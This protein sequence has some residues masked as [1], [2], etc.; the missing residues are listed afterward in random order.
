MVPVHWSLVGA[1]V[2]IKLKAVIPTFPESITE[3]SFNKKIVK[4]TY[5]RP[6][7]ELLHIK[8]GHQ[9]KNITGKT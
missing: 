6:H 5:I 7:L 9:M 4:L 2:G 3:Q 8:I 1:P